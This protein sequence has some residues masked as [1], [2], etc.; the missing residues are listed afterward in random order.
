MKAIKAM[1][2]TT[3][4]IFTKIP[5]RIRARVEG[6]ARYGN[7]KKTL[8]RYDVATAVQKTKTSSRIFPKKTVE[9]DNGYVKIVLI[10]P[11]SK[12]FANVIA[13]INE[14]S[15]GSRLEKANNPLKRA[16]PV[17]ISKNWLEYPTSY[18]MSIL[19]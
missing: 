10:M 8:A 16:S 12:G 19:D 4:M 13:A 17:S 7:T 18:C 2:E 15:N 3:T 6:S 9:R 14:I 1:K 11:S 5:S